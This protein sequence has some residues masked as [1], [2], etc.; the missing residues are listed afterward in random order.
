SAS[1]EGEEDLSGSIVRASKPIAVIAGHE[2]A[3]VGDGNTGGRS[4]E[5]RDFMVE[6]MVPVEYWDNTGYI[7]IPMMD[8]PNNSGGGLGEDLR[9]LVY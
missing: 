9:I 3:N 8:S 6:Q 4:L 7:A 5:A 1:L 2:D